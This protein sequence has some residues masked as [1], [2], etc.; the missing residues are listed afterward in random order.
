MP[1]KMPRKYVVEMFCDRV[2]ASMIYQGKNYSDKYPL[3][4]FLRGKQNRFIH[5][6]TSDEI[7][8]LLTMLAENGEKETFKFIKKWVRE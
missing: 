5:P 3:D 2:A 1:V 7:E 4:Y 6:D 8:M